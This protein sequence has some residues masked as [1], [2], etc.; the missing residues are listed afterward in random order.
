MQAVLRQALFYM[1]DV[2]K[3][4]TP[5]VMS[6]PAKLPYIKIRQDVNY[7]AEKLCSLSTKNLE[8]DAFSVPK[9]REVELGVF[10]TFMG[11]CASRC[12]RPIGILHISQFAYIGLHYA[13]FS[14]KVNYSNYCLEAYA[15]C[16]VVYGNAKLKPDMDILF[17]LDRGG[18]LLKGSKCVVTA[19]PLLQKIFFMDPCTS[20]D[21]SDELQVN[22]KVM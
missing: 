5:S 20:E 21:I 9:T 6:H 11:L 14:K 22:I 1:H 13:D 17:C 18:Q 19:S 8:Q 2:F 16:L 7:S 4:K 15:N 10:D 12:N 3:W